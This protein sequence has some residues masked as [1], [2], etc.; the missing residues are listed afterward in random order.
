M[1]Y[2]DRRGVETSA[3][4]QAEVDAFD[5]GFELFLNY[6]M[7]AGGAMK[8]VA[9]DHPDSVLAG[10]LR[11]Y[12]L[13]MLES[14]ALHQKV[15]TS[16]ESMLADAEHANDRERNHLQALSHWADGDVFAAASVWD[17]LLADD[18]LDLLALK[19]HHYTTFW[20]GRAGVLL[21]TVEGVLDAWS[22]ETPGYDHVLGMHA[23]GLNETGRHERAEAVARGAVDRNPEDLWSIHAVA[24]ALEMQGDHRR[25]DVF[26]EPWMDAWESKNP[27]VGHIWWHAALFPWNAGD[28]DR[29]LDLYDNRLRPA[30]TN[31]FLDIQ[32]LSSLLTR[33]ELAGVDVGDRWSELGDHAADRTGDHVLAFTDLHCALTLAR[34]ERLDDLKAFLASLEEHLAS[35][36]ARSME[37]AGTETAVAITSGLVDAASGNP[38]RASQKLLPL[39]GDLAPIGGSHAQRDLFDLL[40]ADL[41]AA[42]GDTKMAVK[43][44]RSRAARWPSSVP[45]WERYSDALHAAGQSDAAAAAERRAIEVRGQ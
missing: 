5:D 25:G 20:T 29:V 45:T 1:T 38:H 26:F 21:S 18:P 7:S 16:A 37:T 28:Y 31:F 44:L 43:L 10:I 11:G 39:R 22:D 42:G 30:S 36:R 15:K 33:L 8:Q 12:M 6:E 14:T 41:T 17:R 32:N 13:M 3:Q 9:A 40:L 4:N 19:L 27:F 2:V 34:T 23:F 24:H 35:G